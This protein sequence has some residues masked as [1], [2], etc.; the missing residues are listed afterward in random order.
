MAND[1]DGKKTTFEISLKEIDQVLSL[2][3]TLFNG[4]KQASNLSKDKRKELNLAL[5]ETAEMISTILTTV[6][7]RISNIIK[8]IRKESPNVRNEIIELEH[9]GD[10]EDQ[11]RRFRM[12][13]PLANAAT[14]LDRGF[15][16]K[17]VDYFSF[18]DTGELKATIE[19]F[20]SSE[21]VVG[22]FVARLFKDLV[23]L[24]EKVET[25]PDFV[26]AEF[27]KA[28]DKIEEYRDRFI[29]IEKD[30]RTNI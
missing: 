13:E 29:K 15:F 28:R 12:C 22:E 14:E 8:E 19:N 3:E 30:I 27:E 2:L 23:R 4:V 5:T 17:L 10:W 1:N 26:L 16:T 24:E 21:T 20:I 11:Y 18:K 9:P 25:E 6:K 7:Q